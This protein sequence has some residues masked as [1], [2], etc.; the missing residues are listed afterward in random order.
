MGRWGGGEVGR[1]GGGEVGRWGGGEVGRWGGGE[2]G[3]WGGG[4]VGRWGGGEVGRWGGGEVRKCREP[5]QGL[6]TLST[7]LLVL[8]TLLIH[9]KG[10]G[11][12]K[13]ITFGVGRVFR[14]A[15]S[16]CSK[17]VLPNLDG[18]C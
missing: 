16:R 14:R 18:F 12:G 5:T 11:W 6:R 1:W 8:A 13:K 17:F 7:S 15:S 2:V 10:A 9:S 4:E 3:R